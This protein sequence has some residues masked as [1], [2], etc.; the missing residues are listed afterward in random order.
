MAFIPAPALLDILSHLLHTT[1]INDGRQLKM[2]QRHV[3][4]LRQKYINNPPEGMT[5]KLVRNMTDSDLLDMHY[6]LIEDDDF[7]D[8]EFERRVLYQSVLTTA[9]FLYP[10]LAV[11][12]VS[13]TPF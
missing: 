10:P 8:D 7:N 9:C 4:E 2:N 3:D 11:S 5:P 12:L 1:F 6:F 13:I